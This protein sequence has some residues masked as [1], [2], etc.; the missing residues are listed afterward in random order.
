M[1][2]GRKLLI[3]SEGSGWI[4]PESSAYENEA[5]LQEILATDPS[6]IP[7]VEAGALTAT[8]LQTGG[9]PA[10]V[11]VVGRD[12]SIVVVECK[13]ATNSER[14]RM[15]IGQ[16]IDYAAAIWSA[17]AD[18]FL[19]SWMQCANVD[20]TSE[21]DDAALQ[22]LRSNISDGRIDLCFAVDAIDDDLRRLVE[23][24]NRVTTAEISVTSLQLSYAKHGDVEILIPTTFG[25]EL[26]EAKARKSKNASTAKVKPEM[27]SFLLDVHK[28]LDAR[29]A[30]T[31]ISSLDVLPKSR[32]IKG[33]LPLEAGLGPV[34][35]HLK[36]GV[37]A[38]DAWVRLTIE[39]LDTG[40]ENLAAIHVLKRRYEGRA[41]RFTTPIQEW[42]SEN[43]S[44]R[45][46]YAGS[47]HK[48]LG[49]QSD[50][51]EEAATWA[52]D[53]FVAWLELLI[54]DPVPDIKKAVIAQLHA[55]AAS[56]DAP[57]DE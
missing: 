48:G 12:G 22:A 30:R 54:S 32:Y 19:E 17:G 29:L 6:Q 27:T 1:N 38:S 34:D 26:V 8:E 42:G 21:L 33:R 55:D 4:E 43:G 51:V 44:A 9:G 57:A 49:Y 39:A 56:S 13:L 5:H 31:Q 11:C 23:Y 37:T 25:G 24:L 10:D 15:V 3:R 28:R 18:A 7:G 45:R 40:E 35:G 16:V 50:L 46:A 41:A 53:M 36:F 47:T 20:L 52:H 2:K 14:R